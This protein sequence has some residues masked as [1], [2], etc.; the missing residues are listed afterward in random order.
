[1]NG[2]R[3]IDDIIAGHKAAGE[4]DPELWMLLSD[5]HDNDLG[6]ML[7]NRLPRREGY[8]LVYIGLTPVGR[9]K[10]LADGLMRTAINTLAQ[11]GGGQIIT[12]CDAQNAPARKLYH[13]H[14]FSHLY[15]EK[16]W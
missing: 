3:E 11:E 15:A 13:R 7:L 12:A 10:R 4:F 5:I 14:G 9:G 1:M 8:E 2:R 6:V 16:R